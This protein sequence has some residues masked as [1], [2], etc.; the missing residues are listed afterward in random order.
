MNFSIG[1]E[2]TTDAL[3]VRRCPT[4]LLWLQRLHK[5]QNSVKRFLTMVVYSSSFLQK[6]VKIYL[7]YQSTSIFIVLVKIIRDPLAALP[8]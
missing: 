2:P 5:I 7:C 3:A 8:A 1:V 6:R 4:A